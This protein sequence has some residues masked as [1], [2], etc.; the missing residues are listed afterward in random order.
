MRGVKLKLPGML[1]A[2]L[3][4]IYFFEDI[5]LSGLSKKKRFWKDTL[6]LSGLSKKYFFENRRCRWNAGKNNNISILFFVYLDPTFC[7]F[8]FSKYLAKCILAT[9]I[10]SSNLAKRIF[11][12]WLFCRYLAKCIRQIF[13]NFI[14]FIKTFDI[15]FS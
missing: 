11:A 4:K 9:K 5:I 3:T 14:H 10:F 6:P 15:W 7:Y 12:T 2:W 13:R 1:Y 8:L